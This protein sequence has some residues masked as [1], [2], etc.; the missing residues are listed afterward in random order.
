MSTSVATSASLL[1]NVTRYEDIQKAG[2]KSREEMG[3]QDFLTLFTAQLK[4]QNPLDPVKNEAFVAQLAQFSQLEAL[5]NMQGSLDKFVTAMSAERLLGGVSMIGRK[6][7][8]TDAVTPLE[9][10]GVID[11]SVDLPQGASGISLVVY[12][13]QG[14]PVQELI[15][16]ARNPGTASL[17]WDGLDAMG[18][19]AP[20]G[21]YR[22]KA[23]A[24]VNGKTVDVPVSTYNTVRAITT[25]P[26]DGSVSLDVDGG[27]TVRLTDV[28]RVGM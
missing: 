1:G 3:K 8:V 23:T 11:A 18:N 20:A 5:T 28:Q 27:K 24:V 17:S 7:A 10:G 16:G 25:N 2:P 6:V 4:N 22:L 13:S 12:D 9:Q 15:G 21:Y 14:R 26:L 19:P